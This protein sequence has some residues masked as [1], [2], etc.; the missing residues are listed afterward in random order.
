MSTAVQTLI[1]VETLAAQ[2]GDPALRIFDCRS[3]LTDPAAGRA[4]YSRGHLPRARYAH[5]NDELRT[6]PAAGRRDLRGSLAQ[7]GGR[8]RFSGRRL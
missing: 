2:L 8:P 3:D 4:A 7:L 6:S 5:L 1:D